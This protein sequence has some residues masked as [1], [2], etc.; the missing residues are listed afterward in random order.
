[1]LYTKS[2][3]TEENIDIYFTRPLGLLWAR[4]FNRLGVH[5]NTVTYLSILLGIA[6][7]LCFL[8]PSYRL[9]GWHGLLWNVLGVLLLV[10]ANIYDSADGQLAR[11][12]GKSSRYG[13]ILDGAAENIWYLSIYI[14]LVVRIWPEWGIWG[15]LVFCLE[16]FVL[17]ANQS[18]MADYIRNSYLYMQ[19]G[20]HQD[21]LQEQL[22]VWR[23]ISFREHPVEKTLQ[24]FYLN[25]TFR[26]ERETPHLQKLMSYLHEHFGDDIPEDIR[27]RY[28]EGTF[29]LLKWTNVLTFNWRA[30]A[31]YI[32]VLT[33]CIPLLMVVE[34]ILLTVIQYY[35][36]IRHERLC[37]NLLS[38]ISAAR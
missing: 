10:W 4:F 12:S 37:R 15:F 14:C 28:L 33:D 34:C 26:Q 16:G 7:G 20:Q 29:P 23:S 18:R 35:M 24:M 5:P 22:A 21:R 11:M 36:H 25:Y 17:H 9:A 6:S 31:L 13:R 2:K 27:R 38:S 3:D 19:N 8:S 30:F 32:S 1:M